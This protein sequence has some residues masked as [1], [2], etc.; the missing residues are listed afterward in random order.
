M[1][2][3]DA[4]VIYPNVA[5]SLVAFPITAAGGTG[6]SRDLHVPA[7]S[8]ELSV[9]AARPFLPAVAEALGLGEVRHVDTGLD[10]VAA[11]REQWDDGNN[12][13]AVAPGV[14]VA[15]ER[16]TG[17]NARSGRP[18]SRCSRSR[19]TSWAPAAAG[20]GA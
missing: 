15:Y 9:G 5:Q 3:R 18:A 4:V 20:H 12:T 1:V 6:G 16:N 11:E 2:D 13:L 19:A 14:V 17:T 10:P 7:A 8:V